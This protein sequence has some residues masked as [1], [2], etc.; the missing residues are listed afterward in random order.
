MILAPLLTFF[1]VS[2]IYLLY[3]GLDKQNTRLITYSLA[4]VLMALGTLTKGPVGLILPLLTMILYAYFIKNMRSLFTKEFTFG[5]IIFILMVLVWLVPA[6]AR[7]GEAYTKEL[8]LNQILGRFVEAFDHK[9]PFYFYFIRFPLE[10]MPWTVFL[11]AA[12]MFLIKNKLGENAVKLISVW[13]ISIFLFFTVS[14]SK[15]DLYILPLYPAAAIA[16]AYYWENRMRGKLRMLIYIAAAMIIIN[17][18]L[19]YFVLPLFDVYKSPKYFSQKIV[20]YVRPDESLVTFRTNPVYW[21]YY[22][23]RKQI[24]E[25]G[26]YEELDKYLKTDNR[27]FC[28]IENN[29]YEEFM[30]SYKTKACALEKDKFYGR[31]KTFTLISNRYN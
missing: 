5:L 20:K 12:V 13:F 26:N 2:A 9:E 17:T 23:N 4:F 3:L 31:E 11:P 25:L 8:L 19:T 30:R 18:L 21:L 24:K 22:C 29:N 15:N 16:V 10:F 7:G 14:K 27:V 1:A 28:I 6:C